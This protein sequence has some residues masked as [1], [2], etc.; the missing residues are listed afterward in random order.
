MV[1]GGETLVNWNN[2][3]QPSDCSGYP[4]TDAYFFPLLIWAGSEYRIGAATHEGTYRGECP[5]HRE[6]LGNDWVHYTLGA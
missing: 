6:T 5:S 2:G 4:R 3:A 1:P